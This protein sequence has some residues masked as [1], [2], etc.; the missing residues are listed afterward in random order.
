M[1]LTDSQHA[2]PNNG[3]ALGQ[4]LDQ[5]AAEFVQSPTIM[6]MIQVEATP[7]VPRLH[8][9][10]MAPTAPVGSPVSVRTTQQDLPPLDNDAY[11]TL[12]IELLLTCAEDLV[13]ATK[14]LDDS[15]ASLHAKQ[16]ARE[17]W[18]DTE[19]WLRDQQPETPLFSFAACMQLLEE[20]LTRQSLGQIAIPALVDR[21]EEMARWILDDPYTARATL[22]RYR[23][24]FAAGDGFD[25]EEDALQAESPDRPRERGL[26]V[27]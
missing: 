6:D 12:A 5:L 8:E 7:A 3:T 19:M 2:T 18:A 1:I 10:N 4:S 21:R 26:G 15:Q 14:V 20:Q 23:T 27:A 13:R 25:D 17:L 9:V 24:I 11:I 16:R 22:N